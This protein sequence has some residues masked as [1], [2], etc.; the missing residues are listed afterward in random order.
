MVTTAQAE[1]NRTEEQKRRE[2]EKTEEPEGISI[3]PKGM[4]RGPWWILV[5][6]IWFEVASAAVGLIQLTVNTSWPVG[7]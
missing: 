6:F 1:Q 7:L 5:G 2:F 3:I 4:E